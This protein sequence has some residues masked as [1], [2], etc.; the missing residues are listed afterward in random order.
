[1]VGCCRAATAAV[2]I[3]A[4]GVVQAATIITV[5]SYDY[6][7]ATGALK[8]TVVEPGDSNLCLVTEHTP[9]DFGHPKVSTTRNCEGRPATQAGSLAEAAAPAGMAAFQSRTLTNTYSTDQRFVAK[10]TNALLHEEAK[11]FDP[12]FGAMVLHRDVNQLATRW[13]YDGLGRKTLEERPDG[14]KTKWTYV[15]CT[16][17]SE[18]DWAWLGFVI[19]QG[20]ATSSA[21]PKVPAAFQRPD[22]YYTGPSEIR[23]TYYVEATPLKTDGVTANGPYTRVY[24][25]SLGRE[26]RTETQGSDVGGSA[27]LIYADMAYDLV[28]NLTIKTLPYAANGGTRYS[29]GYMYD[30]L[31]R[32]VRVY[33]GRAAGGAATT[34]TTYSGLVTTVK[35]PRGYSTKQIKNVLGQVQT[36]IDAKE[37]S[38]TRAYDPMGNLVRVTDALGNVTSLEY[39]NRGRKVA[40]YDPDMGVWGYC[41]D[42]LGQLKAQQHPNGR[43]NNTLASCPTVSDV[44]TVATAVQ[45]WSTVAYDKLGRMTQR[46]E[47]DLVSTWTYDGCANGVGK[48]CTAVADNGY[49][50]T[51]AYDTLG[52]P[53]SLTTFRNATAYTS[54]VAYDPS[55][56]R[57]NSQTYPTGLTINRVYTPLGYASKVV[58]A[59]NGQDLWKAL[60]QDAL[61]HYLQFEHGNG[62]V[63]PTR[64][65]TMGVSRPLRPGQAIRCRAS[66]TTTTSTA[67]SRYG[68][69][70]Q[71]LLRR[72]T[73]TTS[74]TA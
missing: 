66:S 58:D 31:G 36:V 32:V 35:N 1:M 24:Y 67:T 44:G 3:A 16:Y 52:R 57:A 70:L 59:R 48:L 56:G 72:H 73:S 37:G 55:T 9:D 61:G 29:P 26:I 51:H 33:E 41:Y 21:C 71:R 74:S 20:A 13:T 63:T 38:L 43:G 8:K 2:L 42:A 17:S 54:G 6:D 47:A 62:L 39:D 15:F 40:L 19:P 5:T 46:R 50:R 4:C 45:G 22:G 69:T 27:A 64:T 34:E 30:L 25:D 23:P 10:T 53:S 14:T 7:T 65:T 68:P 60:A 12:R 18:P 49:K 11:E 28:G